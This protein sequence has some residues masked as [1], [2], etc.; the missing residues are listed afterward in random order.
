MNFASR[1]IRDIVLGASDGIVTTFAVVSG[2][3]GA[4]LSTDII[5][6]LGFANLFADGISMASGT[7][8]GARSEEDVLESHHEAH[9]HIRSS[10]VSGVAVFFAFI[11]AGALPLVPFMFSV[12]SFKL[13]IIATGFAL[14]IAGS[15]RSVF[16]ERKWFLSGFEMLFVGG[17][18]SVVAYG[19]G[20]FISQLV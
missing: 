16:T 6:I 4:A 3:I 10:L 15:L 12:P 2:V 18:A 5:L 14:F 9:R 8:L 20:Y 1:Y 11:I 7:Y 19:T 17:I 13:S